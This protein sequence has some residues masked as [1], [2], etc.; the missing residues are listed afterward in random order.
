MVWWAEWPLPL[1]STS[2]FQIC[3]YVALDGKSDSKDVIKMTLQN[4]SSI[5]LVA[6][7]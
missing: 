5:T 7:I 2:S 1:M 3:E 6:S 4:R